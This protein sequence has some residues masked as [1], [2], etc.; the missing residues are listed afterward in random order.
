MLQ[1]WFVALD[2]QE[3]LEVEWMLSLHSSSS[4]SSSSCCCCL[5]VYFPLLQHLNHV[6]VGVTLNSQ[7]LV[8]KSS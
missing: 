5:M 4:S 1:I 8:F 3:L 6:L 2:Y 7:I